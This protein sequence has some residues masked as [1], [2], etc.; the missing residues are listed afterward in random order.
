MSSGN[1]KYEIEKGLNESQ[2]LI[3]ICSPNA[4]QSPWVSKEIQ[5]FINIGREVRIIP[6][7]IDGIP[8]S[9]IFDTECFP[10]SLRKLTGD[11]ELLGINIHEMGE[12]AAR[13][14][15]ISH[16]FNLPF[17]SLWQRYEKR[18]RRVITYISIFATILLCLFL[19]T[20]WLYLDR[21]AAYDNL[22]I[23]NKELTLATKKLQADSVLTN[24][25]LRRI[26]A[27]SIRLELQKDSIQNVLNELAKAKITIRQEQK[28]NQSHTKIINNTKEELATTY[29]LDTTNTKVKELYLKYFG[30]IDDLKSVREQLA[31][32]DNQKIENDTKKVTIGHN[33]YG[34]K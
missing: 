3:V 12:T 19:A 33:T 5:H 28:Q 14:K 18:R 8:N 26:Q 32:A 24:N 25:H 9:S 30:S 6:Y 7:I 1:L 20:G 29:A 11:Q 31:I 21:K 34:I 15:V 2:H 10:E 4:A 23:T 27:D 17:D 22:D 16:M 13:I